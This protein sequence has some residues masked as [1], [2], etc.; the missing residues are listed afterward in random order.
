MSGW[1]P[2]AVVGSSIAIENTLAARLESTPVHGDVPPRCGAVKFRPP[3]MSNRLLMPSKS[4]KN[5]SLRGPAKNVTESDWAM[6]GVVPLETS[7][8]SKILS[9]TASADSASLSWARKTSTVWRPSTGS[10]KTKLNAM[11]SRRSPSLSM[12]NR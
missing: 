1:A 6:T 7:T 3:V 10:E 2:S 11:S 9:P 5:A 8:A 12:A 4:K